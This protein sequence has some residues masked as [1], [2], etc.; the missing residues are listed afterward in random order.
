[1][2]SEAA[3][4]SKLIKKLRKRFPDCLVVKNDP[5]ENQ[6]VPDL[7]ILHRNRWGMLEAKC[8]SKATTQPNQ[9]YY[10]DRFND[11]SF[12]S[13]ISPETESEV[14]DELQRVLG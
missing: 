2:P 10:I 11:M 3:Y 5:T 12:A 1:M 9:K 13:F 7:L 8:S 6:G 4:Q 14:L